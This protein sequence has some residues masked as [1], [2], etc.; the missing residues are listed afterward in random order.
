VSR[1]KR[2]VEKKIQDKRKQ[3]VQKQQNKI[4]RLRQ[5]RNNID[6]ETIYEERYV[7]FTDRLGFKNFVD[8]SVDN[9]KLRAAMLED[10]TVDHSAEFKSLYPDPV[11]L[12][13]GGSPK[14]IEDAHV[15]WTS[16]S[17]SIILSASAAAGDPMKFVMYLCHM[18]AARLAANVFIRGGLTVGL[19]R[20]KNNVVFGPAMNRAY[21]LESDENHAKYPR[22]ILE[23][24]IVESFNHVAVISAPYQESGV[25][26]AFEAVRKDPDGT[27]YLNTAG[28]ALAMAFNEMARERVCI[29]TGVENQEPNPTMWRDWPRQ[30][31]SYVEYWFRE[32]PRESSAYEKYVWFANY[33]NDAYFHNVICGPKGSSLDDPIL[34]QMTGT[35]ENV[36]YQFCDPIEIPD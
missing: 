13:D 5:A 12:F 26:P 31:K 30:V 15:E 2:R 25:V 36:G 33:F 27:A 14:E 28:F 29:E 1:N 34:G 21:E 8:Q 9:A 10:L 19:V 11:V 24:D 4:K 16:F 35:G 3:K 22:I 17:D 18:S 32:L 20:H 7:A 23:H 6:P